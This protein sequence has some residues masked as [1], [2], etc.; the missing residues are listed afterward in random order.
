MTR[1]IYCVFLKKYTEGLDFQC[2]PGP[3]GEKIYEKISKQAWEQWKEK[4]TILINEKRLNMLNQ[5]DRNN[6]EIEMQSFLFK[7]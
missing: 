1:I 5:I 4:Q 7:K 6:L 2:Y 3:L